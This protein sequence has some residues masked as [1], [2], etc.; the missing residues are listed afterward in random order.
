MGIN[1]GS[2]AISDIKLGTTQ[3]DKV[4]LGDELVWGGGSALNG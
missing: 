2:T 1:L 3:V 4:Y